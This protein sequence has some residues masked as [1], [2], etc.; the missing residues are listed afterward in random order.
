MENKAKFMTVAEFK[1]EV[2]DD[3]TVKAQVVK[4]PNTGKLFLAVG[5]A[6]FKVQQNIDS[7]K[8]M[9]VLIPEEGISQAC[10]VNVNND[11]NANVLFEL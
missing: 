5:D 10:L 9:S 4:N 11:P 7:A 2:S 1:K 6:R 8:P 3:A